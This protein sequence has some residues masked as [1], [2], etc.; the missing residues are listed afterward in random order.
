MIKDELYNHI[1]LVAKKVNIPEL[2]FENTAMPK[3]IDEIILKAF[4]LGLDKYNPMLK[5][6]VF[7]KESLN[8]TGSLI[9]EEEEK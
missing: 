9:Y 5:E 3:L 6:I 7:Q 4:I 2:F 8:R 1:R